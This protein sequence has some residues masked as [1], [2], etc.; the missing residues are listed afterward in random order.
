MFIEDLNLPDPDMYGVQEV[1]E[2]LYRCR[3]DF[4]SIISRL[5]SACSKAQLESPLNLTK[6]FSLTFRMKLLY[7]SVE[8][9]V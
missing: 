8:W 1:N 4:F 6:N 2:V 3:F 7:W 5:N 9:S